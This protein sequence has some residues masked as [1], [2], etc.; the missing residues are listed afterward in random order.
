M[1]YNNQT[2]WLRVL[3]THGWVIHRWRFSGCRPCVEPCTHVDLRSSSLATRHSQS[4][5]CSALAA[6]SVRQYVLSGSSL[7][8]KCGLPSRAGMPT[9]GESICARKAPQL[10]PMSRSGFSL[11]I[12]MRMYFNASLGWRGRSGVST[13]A[14]PSK[15]SLS[16]L[17]I[18]QL[19]V[20]KKPCRNSIFFMLFILCLVDCRICPFSWLD[21][22]DCYGSAWC[23]ACSVCETQS[24]GFWNRRP[25]ILH[26]WDDL[27]RTGWWQ[28]FLCRAS[29]SLLTRREVV[30]L[31][32][33]PVNWLHAPQTY[34]GQEP[35]P[36]KHPSFPIHR[37]A[38]FLETARSLNQSGHGC[39]Q[40]GWPWLGKIP[41]TSPVP[42]CHARHWKTWIWQ[43]HRPFT[44]QPSVV[45]KAVCCVRSRHFL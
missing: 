14:W 13:I 42:E 17:A 7:S 36:A 4:K 45:S 26:Q 25:S 44:G 5:L 22:N 38:L 2:V 12:R 3:K 16:A 15:A 6:R 28:S 11:S 18:G 31:P 34:A 32:S 29:V 23:H 21:H 24:F 40:Y 27:P 35:L 41:G 30:T 43:V 37:T 9:T 39:W 33:S 19:P 10:L 1:D 8:W 20:A